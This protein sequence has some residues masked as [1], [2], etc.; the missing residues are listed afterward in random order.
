MIPL[1][2]R[3][4]VVAACRDRHDQEPSIHRFCKPRRRFSCRV[5]IVSRGQ[6][7]RRDSTSQ[8]KEW[9]RRINHSEHE[10]VKEQSM[11]LICL[12]YSFKRVCVC[13]ERKIPLKVS[14]PG[15][16]IGWTLSFSYD[17]DGDE[18]EL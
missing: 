11:Y 8:R 7:S 17:M 2:V 15:K 16:Y 9:W 6:F 1:C 5:L 4:G 13:V 3:I 14:V 12:E 18:E 10:S